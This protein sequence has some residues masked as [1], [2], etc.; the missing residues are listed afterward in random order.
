M[1]RKLSRKVKIRTAEKLLCVTSATGC[2]EIPVD[3]ISPFKE[4]PFKVADDERMHELVESIMTEGL[5]S[6]VIV[7]S[8]E[9]GRYEMISGHRRLYAVKQIGLETIPA[10]IRKYS[11]DEAVLA[12]VDYGLQREEVLP[13]EKA[14]AFKM[15][16][17][18]MRRSGKLFDYSKELG[19]RLWADEQLA[20]DVGESRQNVQRFLRITDVIPPILDLVDREV[21][22]VVT[23]VEIA[24]LDKTVQEMLYDYM[25]E[26]DICMAYQLYALRNYLGDNSNI[27]KAELVQVL[28]ENAP[29][30]TSNRFQKIIITKKQLREFF[31]AYY[32]KAQME[33]VLFQLLAEWK[34]ENNKSEG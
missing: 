14:Y 26:N 2:P 23:A 34:R 29:K 7:R 5:L 18:A 19:R 8:C 11:D 32:T 3:T 12:M 9:N 1:S 21:L 13:S 31:P 33:R 27:T 17:E 16:Y 22:A 15:R 6:P 20:K 10:V 28:N 25:M 4:Y 24:H 30:D